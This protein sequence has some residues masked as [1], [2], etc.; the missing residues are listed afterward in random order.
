MVTESA[1]DREGIQPDRKKMD[2]IV[3]EPFKEAQTYCR[4]ATESYFKLAGFVFVSNGFLLAAMRYAIG[5]DMDSVNQQIEGY[6]LVSS[7]LP[8][9]IAWLGLV[10]NLAAYFTFWDIILRFRKIRFK[11]REFEKFHPVSIKFSDVWDRY[12][13][14]ANPKKF[15]ISIANLCTNIFFISMLL[16]WAAIIYATFV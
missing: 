10:C 4:H 11:L 6:T 8:G 16:I 14:S 1:P 3:I 7:I 5:A 9:A 15:K 13:F 12:D 2:A